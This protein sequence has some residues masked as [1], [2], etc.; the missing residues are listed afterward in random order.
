MFTHL[1]CL[2]ALAHVYVLSFSCP[3]DNEQRHPLDNEPHRQLAGGEEEE[4]GKEENT[5]QANPLAEAE[6]QDEHME[7]APQQQEEVLPLVSC[8]S[9]YMLCVLLKDLLCITCNM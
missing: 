7:E 5:A 2:Y 9:V 3:L 4:N 8:V 1:T 6:Y